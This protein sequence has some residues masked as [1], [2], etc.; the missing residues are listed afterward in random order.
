MSAYRN[1][2]FLIADDWSPIAG[3]YGNPVV[4]MPRVDE[5]ASRA[6]LF[7]QAFCTSPSCAVSRA[8]ILT[9]LHSHTHGQ[10]GHCHSIQGFRAHEHIRSLT[11]ILKEHGYATACV[12]KRHVMPDSVFPFDYEPEVNGRSV[13]DL[14]D[15]ALAFLRREGQR[16][17][18]LHVG[19]VDPHRSGRG[20]GHE[21]PWRGVTEV[22]YSP[23]EII[24]PD[25]LP[26]HPHVRRDLALYYQALSRLD[27]GFGLLFDAL[28]ESGHAADTLVIVTTDHGMPFPGAKAAP[29]DTGHRGPLIILNPDLG[30][31]AV[32]NRA[33][34]SW[35]DLMPT[36]LDFCGVPVPEGLPGRSLLSI[37]AEESPTGFDQVF[38]SHCFHEVVNYYPYRV[39][40]E[41]RYKYRLHF[42]SELDL[43]L[44]TDLFRS[45]TWQAILR[46]KL[47]WMGKRPTRTLLRHDREELFDIEA[48]PLEVESLAGKPEHSA[49]LK[50]MREKVL[51]FCE[52]TRDP[53]LENSFQRGELDPSRDPRIAM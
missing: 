29:F 39:L 26:D 22:V 8:C 24:V 14:R 6:T 47:E 7:E 16:P 15:A 9:G 1:V 35:V 31:R 4:K 23:E 20:F 46:D 18:Y 49:R 21:Q 11:R 27:T 32:L 12:G 10:Y 37:L 51:D 43:P 45:P 50:S 33:L 2:L 13:Y 19:F 38:F 48:D 40:R 41:R 36:M 17:F 34:V 28:Q 52:A 5:L 3:C 42:A 25:F 53:W 44:P 30:G